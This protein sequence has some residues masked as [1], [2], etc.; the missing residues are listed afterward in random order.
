MDIIRISK[1]KKKFNY[2]KNGKNIS[3]EDLERIKKLC[4]PPNWKDVHISNNPI[5]HLQVT[6]KDDKDRLQYIYHP[7]WI[8]LTS[9]DKYIRMGKFSKKIGIFEKKIKKDLNTNNKIYAILFT[10]LKHTHIRVGN[11]CYAKENKTYGLVTLEKRHVRLNNGIIYL[12]FNG[13]KSVK[14]NLSFKDNNCYSY[15]KNILSTL[16]P[17]DRIFPDICGASVNKYLQDTMGNEFTCK[18]FR[19]YASN[20]LFLKYLCSLPEPTSLKDIKNNLKNV[21]DKVAEKLGHTRAVSRNSYVMKLIPE[22]YIINP[23]QFIN[24]NPK[25]VFSKLLRLN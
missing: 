14:Q 11:E 7:M 12:N 3:R 24:K 22:Q 1:G 19:T 10:I 2:H 16:K 9:S 20:I 15:L 4:I 18:D 6:G 13:K 8:F 5:S 25:V 17:N 21:Y 23:K